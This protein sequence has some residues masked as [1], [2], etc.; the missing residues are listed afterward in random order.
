ML[1]PHTLLILPYPLHSH[2]PFIRVQELRI[3]LIV[4][5]KVQEN[6]AN[7]RGEEADRQEHNLPWLD[8]SPMFLDSN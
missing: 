6:T 1:V 4:R 7:R 2:Q 3:Q 8:G 5:H